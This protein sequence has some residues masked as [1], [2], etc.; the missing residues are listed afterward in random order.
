MVYDWW[1]TARVYVQCSDTGAPHPPGVRAA[2]S[3]PA[4]PGTAHYFPAARRMHALL[5]DAAKLASAGASNIWAILMLNL[6]AGGGGA[7]LRL[8]R[9]VYKHSGVQCWQLAS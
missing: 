9:P 1:A 7:P 8:V 3:M 4:P 2:N 6:A 5:L